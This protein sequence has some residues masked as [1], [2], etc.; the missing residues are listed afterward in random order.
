MRQ[1]L[2]DELDRK[3][4]EDGVIC[5]RNV[6][7]ADTLRLAKEALQWSQK[8]PLPTDSRSPARPFS[9]RISHD[10]ERRCAC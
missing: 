5:L 7:T 2:S 4:R 3:W 9:T 1:Y 10:C 8:Y 6:L